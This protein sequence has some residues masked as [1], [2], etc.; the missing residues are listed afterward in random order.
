MAAVRTKGTEL[1][2]KVRAALD[3]IG[4]PFATN[5]RNLPGSPDIVVETARAVIFVHGCYWHRH[6][7]PITNRPKTS[8]GTDWDA[9]FEANLRRDR[10]NRADLLAAG[11]RVLTVWGCALKSR[12]RLTQDELR[13]ALRF[14]LDS[15][16]AE[17]V[18]QGKWKGHD[19]AGDRPPG[20]A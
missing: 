6:D 12:A 11:W 14:W 1:E 18:I 5:R 7:C 10:R 3:D 8:A 9:K 13:N 15:D 16:L 4:R 20:L 19:D 2:L 17:G